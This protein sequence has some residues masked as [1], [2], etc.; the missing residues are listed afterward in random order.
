MLLHVFYS[1]LLSQIILPIMFLILSLLLG[2]S[3]NDFFTEDGLLFL[4]VSVG[5][6]LPCILFGWLIII[7]I[8]FA[9]LTVMAKFLVWIFA[10]A[11]IVMLDLWIFYL[12]IVNRMEFQIRDFVIA[13]PGILSIWIA[14]IIRYKQ[15]QNLVHKKTSTQ[16]ENISEQL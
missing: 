9:E 4:I 10:T 14:S 5:V 13:L 16:L 6:S 12:I 15:F 2:G 3:V 11:I 8:V 7:P 1:W